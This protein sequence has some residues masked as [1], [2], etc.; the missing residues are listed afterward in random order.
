MKDTLPVDEKYRI[1][2]TKYFEEYEKHLKTLKIS[3][4]QD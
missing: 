3:E 2:M 4:K 1:Q